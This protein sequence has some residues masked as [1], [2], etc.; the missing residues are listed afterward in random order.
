VLELVSEL[1]RHSVR[2]RAVEVELATAKR[3]PAEMAALMPRVEAGAT[4]RLADLRKAPSRPDDL[5]Q[6]VLA[7]FPDGIKLIPDEASARQVWKIEARPDLG[8]LAGAD[9]N[10]VVTP[11][12]IAPCCSRIP[13]AFLRVAF[14][15]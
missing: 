3:T 5:R 11:A 12:G 4:A 14:A 13:S 8:A 15:A 10:C 6:V 9:S 1:R 7:L 2:L